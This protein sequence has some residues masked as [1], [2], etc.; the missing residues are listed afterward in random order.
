M[1]T[2]LLFQLGNLKTAPRI[3]RT[4]LALK[5]HYNIYTAGYDPI[6]VEGEK[7]IDLST[8]QSIKEP[9]IDFHFKY[10]LPIRKLISLFI[11]FFILKS[12][13]K[14]IKFEKSYWTKQRREIENFLKQKKFDILIVHGIDALP[15]AYNLCKGSGAKL[16]FNAHEYYPREFEEN[17]NWMIHTQPFYDYLCRTYMPKAD[18]F[19]SV[20]ENIRKEYIKNYNTDS[21]VITNAGEYKDLKVKPCQE[22]I[23]IIH[24]GVAL[25]GRNLE[26]MIRCAELLDDRFTLD[27]MLVPGDPGYFEEIKHVVRNYKKVNLIDPVE[28]RAI[29]EFLNNYDIGLYILPVTNFNNE[30]ALPNKFFE[31]I[32]GRLMLAIS[33]NPEMALLT[34]KYR[35]GI[36]AV[37]YTA[38][39]MATALNKLSVEAINDFKKN[40]QKAAEEMNAEINGQLILNSINQLCAA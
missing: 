19:F 26:T 15:L 31:F 30:M 25:R 20:S 36:V 6:S 18:L 16:V 9:V 13:N 8:F 10:P 28:F 37:D 14:K 2:V 32:Q 4:Y 40:S 21:I 38:G 34:A 22:R 27:L 17:K 1:K 5:N 35:L 3:Y 39:S 24:H 29:P 11:N 12:F 33:P 7:Y 23:R